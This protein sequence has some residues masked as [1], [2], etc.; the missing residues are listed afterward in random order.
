MIGPD[1]RSARG[2]SNIWFIVLPPDVDTC[3]APGQCATTAFAGY[4][5]EFDLGHG[6]TIYVPIPDPLVEFTPPP[7]PIPRATRRPSRRSTRWPTRPRRRSPTR[8]GPPGWTPTASRSPTS[9]SPAAS[10]APR[11]GYAP[12][13]SPYNQLINGHEYLLPGHVVQRR[14]R[15]ACRARTRPVRRCRCTRSRCASSARSSAAASASHERVPVAVDLI[16][17]GRSRGRGPHANAR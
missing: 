7:A 13:G 2:L 10:R 8:T 15:A 9:A 5:S 16:R 4:H 14:S 1:H 11:S 6:P 17:A 12:D 3:I